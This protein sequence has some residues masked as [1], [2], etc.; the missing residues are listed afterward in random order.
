MLKILLIFTL[1][2][3][4]VFAQTLS[5]K[6][7]IQRPG[8]DPECIEY[9]AAHERFLL[10]SLSEGTIFEVTDDGTITPFIEDE[11]LVSSV[12]IEVDG[13]RLLVTNS[14]RNVFKSATAEGKASL[15]AYDL[16]TGERL[17]A[18]DL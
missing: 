5:E 14:D 8:L 11:D 13:D 2:M 16:E 15:Y 6:M 7:I 4:L 1:F 17:F 10:G 18:V 12:G 9:D 3:G